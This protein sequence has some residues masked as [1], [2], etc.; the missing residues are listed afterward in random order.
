MLDARREVRL[1]PGEVRFFP[2]KTGDAIMSGAAQALAGAVERMA[3]FMHESGQAAPRVV[4]SGGS[5]PVLR[6]LL[7][8][9]DTVVVEHLV[10][11]GLAAIAE[12]GC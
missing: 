12:E 2:D 5:A 4:L 1:Q 6:P 3:F 11:E 7:A 8:N 9:L 10:L